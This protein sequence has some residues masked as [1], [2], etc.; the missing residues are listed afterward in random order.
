[1]RQTL[2][3][4]TVL[5]SYYLC[6]VT[7][8]L[9]I[10]FIA[11]KSGRE[12]G[13]WYR[14]ILHTV[15]FSSIIPL[16]LGFE[17]WLTPFVTE[18]SLLAVIWIVLIILEKI[19]PGLF[20]SIINERKK[21]EGFRSFVMSFGIIAAVIAVCW[22]V[23]GLK[24]LAVMSILTWGFSDMAANIF[25]RKF[26]KHKFKLKIADGKK[27]VEGSAADF[28]VSFAISLV[29]LLVFS[30]ISVMY[31]IAMALI[32]GFV[33]AFAE[34]ISKNGNDTVIAPA[35]I[36]AV[37]IALVKLSEQL[38]VLTG[39]QNFTIII[40]FFA[41][42]G[43]GLGTG[44]CGLSAAAVIVPMLFSFL[45]VPAYQATAVALGSDVLASASSAA[46]YARHKNINLKYGT[47]MLI[48]ISIATIIG[49]IAA[50]RVGN[51][52]LGS[53][54]I[55]V[56]ACLG[57]KFLIK[58]V[59]SH[60][61]APEG[62]EERKKIIQSLIC[63]IAIGGLCGF[64]GTGGGTLMLIVLTAVIGFDLKTAVGTSVYIMTA[65]ALIGS[66]T[67]FAVGGIPDLFIT[68]LTVIFTLIWAQIGAVFANK[69]S[70]NVMNRVCGAVLLILGI[71]MMIMKFALPI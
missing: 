62:K 21:G 7:A 19:K 49:S 66:V 24:Y 37:S 32:I 27:S 42:M 53:I 61:F 28:V 39:E 13:E 51:F 29:F 41:G 11:R 48:S 26:G 64:I 31:C 67:H 17:N 50:H 54:S 46:V 57:I 14:K 3:G 56:T 63:G 9:L 8:V 55:I 45:N 71:A 60:K 47:I 35:A 52:A 1:M 20:G 10:W 69:V 65:T 5:G 33:S 2:T 68:V 59:K 30:G 4:I 34:L 15:Q 16:T 40:C 6:A 58:P 12:T 25:G 23:F 43:A 44:L 22:G 70:P 18:L 38:P 36:A